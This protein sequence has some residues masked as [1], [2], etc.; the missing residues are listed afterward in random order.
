ME[1]ARHRTVREADAEGWAVSL[2][3]DPEDTACVLSAAAKLR[4]LRDNPAFSVSVQNAE[5]K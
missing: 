2:P 4:I 3:P 5:A 1:A